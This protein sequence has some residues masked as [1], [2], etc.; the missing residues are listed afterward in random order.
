M[1]KA[2]KYKR[3]HFSSQEEYER[4]RKRMTSAYKRWLNKHE[5]K[6]PLFRE[7]RLLRQRLYSRYY[8]HSDGRLS[9]KDW[10]K[11]KYAIEDIK[12]VPIDV[13]RDIASS[14]S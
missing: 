5:S 14:K 3:E 9:F 2:Y 1:A 7:F 4:F 12:N 10:L 6:D 11:D 13:L 8:W